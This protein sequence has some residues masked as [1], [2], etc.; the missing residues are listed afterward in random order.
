MATE[1]LQQSALSCAVNAA[2]LCVL[3]GPSDK[4]VL[5]A[6]FLNSPSAVH[7]RSDGYILSF[8]LERQLARNLAFLAF[9]EDDANC[10]PAVCVEQDVARNALSI[11]VANNSGEKLLDNAVQGLQRIF[12]IMAKGHTERNV[13]LEDEIFT[14]I[15][16]MCG[17]R[18]LTRLQLQSAKRGQ[19]KHNKNINPGSSTSFATKLVDA[20]ALLESVKDA[21]SADMRRAFISGAHK[22][23]KEARGWQTYQTADSLKSLISAV[24]HLVQAVNVEHVIGL[25]SKQDLVQTAQ[26]SLINKA[27][28]ISRY[29]ETARW[30]CDHA[31]GK[32]AF[33]M[34]TAIRLDLDLGARESLAKPNDLQLYEVIRSALLGSAAE[35]DSASRMLRSMTSAVDEANTQFRALLS[36]T[37]K[38]AKV[39][40]EVKLLYFYEQNRA[41]FPLMPRVVCSSKDACWLCNALITAHGQ[42]FTPRCHGVLYP[43]WRQPLI[44][45]LVSLHGSLSTLVAEGLRRQVAEVALE[46]LKPK[47][48]RMV[49]TLPN[50]SSLSML[51]WSCST[52]HLPLGEPLE[53]ET[54]AS[55]IRKCQQPPRNKLHTPT[56]QKLW[57]ACTLM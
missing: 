25:I 42:M 49:F 15:V 24:N 16:T 13:E 18:I 22:V 47:K 30:L 12:D 34:L 54:V 55:R 39:H 8:E 21:G 37:L 4:A 35:A 53:A 32:R 17:P 11:R 10:I 7:M 45:G 27:C 33:R 51:R 28:K 1:I 38:Q 29:R 44:P 48:Q 5:A 52:L 36:R 9:A 31:R 2:A 14:A 6:P 19:K 46:L 23:A 56:P 40:A 20:A 57:S 3:H 50:E 43:N 41:T 26:T